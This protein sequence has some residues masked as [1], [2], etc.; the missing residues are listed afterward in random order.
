MYCL[1]QHRPP[2]CPSPI[3]SHF[4][5]S[6]SNLKSCPKFRCTVFI[7]FHVMPVSASATIVPCLTTVISKFGGVDQKGAVM[8]IFRSLGALSRALGPAVAS[9]GKDTL[10]SPY[11]DSMKKWPPLFSW[12][13]SLQVRVSG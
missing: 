4:K 13:S 12:Q 2:L 9:T 1:F 6:G 10:L 7:P 5:P 3:P 8:G 11:L